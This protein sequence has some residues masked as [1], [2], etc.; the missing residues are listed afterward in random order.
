MDY[1]YH[2]W[3]KQT[4]QGRPKIYGG[5]GFSCLVC[6][7]LVLVKYTHEFNWSDKVEV[8]LLPKKCTTAGNQTSMFKEFTAVVFQTTRRWPQA[9]AYKV[10]QIQIQH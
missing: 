1:Q 4:N 8:K 6:V 3:K 2:Q 10:Q 7:G 5:P 9:D